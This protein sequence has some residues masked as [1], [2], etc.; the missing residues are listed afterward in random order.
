MRGCAPTFKRYDCAV[1]TW[2]RYSCVCRPLYGKARSPQHSLDPLH[3]IFGLD[4]LGQEFQSAHVEPPI[5]VLD[6]SGQLPGFF[7][8]LI[9]AAPGG[10][11]DHPDLGGIRVGLEALS[12][13]VAVHAGHHNVH[14]DEVGLHGARLF[15]PLVAVQ[16]DPQYISPEQAQGRSD[17]DA[18]TDIYSLGV[19]LYELLVGRVPFQADTPYAVVHDHIFTPLPMPRSLNPALPE[20]FERVLLKALSKERDDRYTSVSDFLAA[21]EKAAAEAAQAASTVVAPPAAPTVVAPIPS[22]PVEKPSQ[23]AAP[24]A[25]KSRRVLWI[26]LGGIGLLLLCVAAF[27]VATSLSGR[28]Q[29]QSARKLRDQGKVDPA[30]AEYEAAAKTNAR[31]LSAYLEPAEMLMNRGQP[32]DFLRAA[33][34]CQQGLAVMPNNP[35]LRACAERPALPPPGGSS[36]GPA[37]LEQAR[38]LRDAGKVEQALQAYQAV[39]RADPNIVEAYAEPAEMLIASGQR[40]DLA[41]AAEWCEQGLKVDADNERLH[42]CAAIGWLA[43]RAYERARPHLQWWVERCPDCTLP[44]A[45]LAII[46]AQEGRL[47]E[48]Q[49]QAELAI[50]LSE[51]APE[52]HLA[53]GLV[54]LKRGQPQQAREQFK[55]VMES[56][57]PRWIKDQAPK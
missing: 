41:H 14:D 25:R 44:H 39:V 23:P 53:L 21:M 2:Q 1:P 37:S 22:A 47:D 30:L 7:G 56:K 19:V 20:P 26:A 43:A 11:H 24:A 51:N 35:E 33:Q 48:A 10:E 17:L 38:Q 50:R 9:H 40:E 49:R 34:I 3:Q 45:G 29:L 36:T 31:L 18:R 6:S 32:G 52:G 55:I 5:P 57:A 8:I 54:L 28:A 46:L 12:D 15:Q 27:L 4:R 13:L 16:G 42:E